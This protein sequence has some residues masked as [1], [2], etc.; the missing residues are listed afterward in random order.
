MFPFSRSRHLRLIERKQ[1]WKARIKTHRIERHGSMGRLRLIGN[2]RD[3]VRLL[4]RTARGTIR[5]IRPCEFER[6]P[7]IVAT[8][9]VELR[10]MIGE[11]E[12]MFSQKL[13][14]ANPG[15]VELCAGLCVSLLRDEHVGKTPPDLRIA[16]RKCG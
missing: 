16:A 9:G 10:G 4:D 6:A 5:D 11:G 7:A 8:T 2:C 1:K 13:I 15:S 3:G 14:E 12:Q